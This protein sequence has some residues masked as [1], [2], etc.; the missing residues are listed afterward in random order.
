M[1]S[2]LLDYHQVIDNEYFGGA[3]NRF[4]RWYFYV[5][6]GLQ[7]FNEFRY[8]IMT[9][10]G[11]YYL[12]KMHS[13]VLLVAMFLG[14]FVVLGVVGWLFVIKVNK[15]IEYLNVHFSTVWSKHQISLAEDTVKYLKQ[16]NESIS[17]RN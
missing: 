1:T 12:F 8:L 3:K 17:K 14:S 15:V 13:V 9:V 16:I 10:F 11:A 2:Q 6:K 4:I 5:N 7:A